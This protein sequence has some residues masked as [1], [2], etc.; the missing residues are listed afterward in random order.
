[1]DR[2]WRLNREA[3][4]SVESII[5]FQRKYIEEWRDG[6]ILASLTDLYAV[7]T[8][9]HIERKLWEL[10]YSSDCQGYYFVT[11]TQNEHQSI[12]VPEG[13]E[14]VVMV[15]EEEESKKD[16]KETVFANTPVSSHARLDT[17]HKQILVPISSSF[18]S[19]TPRM[20]HTMC[21]LGHALAQQV[22]MCLVDS[23]GVVTRCCVYDYIQAPLE[24]SGEALLHPGSV[25]EK[26][27]E[28]HHQ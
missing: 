28:D 5:E 13:D 14:D 1:M 9:L 17:V 23:H 12:V 16:T 22:I 7:Y 18:N 19:L 21:S 3:L 27:Q 15:Q 11:C 20:I 24:G 25:V 8:V 26:K 2:K 10:R 4:H 6:A